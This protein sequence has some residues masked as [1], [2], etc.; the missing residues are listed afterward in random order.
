MKLEI[1]TTVK[2]NNFGVGK[3]V[4]YLPG[5]NTYLIYF[6][7]QHDLHNGR[8]PYEGL[9]GYDTKQYWWCQPQHLEVISEEEYNREK[10][11]NDMNTILEIGTKVK[12]E[13]F[14]IGK[15]MNYVP[16]DKI[17][18]VYFPLCNDLHN[19]S[20][21]QR[22]IEGRDT[23]QYWWGESRHFTVISEE[24]YEREKEVVNMNIKEL[25]DKF[26]VGDTIKFVGSGTDC[27]SIP[28]Q[29]RGSKLLK[30]M[31]YD[32]DSNKVSLQILCESNGHTILGLASELG[33]IR[34]IDI[35]KLK[36]FIHHTIKCDCCGESITTV[37]FDSNDNAWCQDCLDNAIDN[38][39]M[40]QCDNCG[41]YVPFDDTRYIESEGITV[42]YDCYDDNYRTC[43]E[44]GEMYH[45][46]RM[47]YHERSD[48][49][50]CECC[51][52][53]DSEFQPVYNPMVALEKGKRYFGMELEVENYDNY[54]YGI[55]DQIMDIMGKETIL[56][57]KEDGSLDN[58]GFE[59]VFQPLSE[60]YINSDEFKDKLTK[61]SNLL[62][63][64]NFYKEAPNGGL[65]IHTTRLGGEDIADLYTLAK[66]FETE[67]TQI[68]AR[69]QSSWCRIGGYTTDYVK[70][71]NTN[72]EI[73][74]ETRYQWWNTTNYHTIECRAFDSSLDVDTILNDYN[75]VINA[76]KY[77]C[78]K[79]VNNVTWD[80]LMGKSTHI[81]KTSK[82]YSVDTLRYIKQMYKTN[83]GKTRAIKHIMSIMDKELRVQL[84]ALNYDKVVTI[85]NELRQ[86]N[87][88]MSNSV[89]LKDCSL[90]Y[91]ARIS[92]VLNIEEL[93]E[94]V[95]HL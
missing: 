52:P 60:E 22:G 28:Y 11:V 18:L 78:D 51:Y 46:D 95:R 62:Q 86:L 36:H 23:T 33:G 47:Y 49:W 16:A 42:C 63:R 44:C 69:F 71:K 89:L 84:D 83:N 37:I 20:L 72:D 35:E 34:Q 2:H 45:I 10:E 65:H 30:V 39:E 74:G 24:E 73:Q 4:N 15:V 58:G 21:P 59:I 3:V 14:G 9:P 77:R 38:N 68:N 75:F 27:N 61:L 88:I 55:S 8:H 41:E 43:E 29:I 31:E 90:E 17:Y 50:Y 80:M 66:F 79:K 54:S 25:M 81:T 76:F 93:N 53:G 19:G 7:L 5:D 67:L 32:T 6:P 94:Y 85:S 13:S 1:G 26:K 56:E 64:N 70:N 82:V 92:R 91:I 87:N 12:H 40:I 57:I 48:S